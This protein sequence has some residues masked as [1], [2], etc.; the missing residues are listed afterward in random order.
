MH[1]RLRNR[2]AE[3]PCMPVCQ[4]CAIHEHHSCRLSRTFANLVCETTYPPE[5]L[6]AGQATRAFTTFEHAISAAAAA[7]NGKPVTLLSQLHERAAMPAFSAG[8]SPTGPCEAVGLSSS[9]E[10]PGTI[11][12]TLSSLLPFGLLIPVPARQVTNR[13][14]MDFPRHPPN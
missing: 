2:H 3:T 11:A 8:P 1:F 10:L 5:L 13:S 7:R 4:C 12:N 6:N 9:S 14:L